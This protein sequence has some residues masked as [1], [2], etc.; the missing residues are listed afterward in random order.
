MLRYNN[1]V[2]RLAKR[3]ETH[4]PQHIID[5]FVD[6]GPLFT[7]LS[8]PDNQII[9]G[10]RGTGKTHVLG[11]LAS[12]LRKDD[13]VT[14][15]LDMRTIGS[16][17]GIYSDPNIQLG[18]R[19]TRLLVD[20]L[21]AIHDQVLTRV[22]ED[23]ETLDLSQIGPI[24][25]AFAETSTELTVEGG[26]EQESTSSGSS[27]SS[28]KTGVSFVAGPAPAI[29]ADL[30]D[31]SETSTGNVSRVKQ[32]GAQRLRV[33][34]GPLTRRLQQLVEALPAKSLWVILDEWSEVP[35]D[36]QPYLADFLRRCVIPAKGVTVKIAAIAQR[37]NF[38]IEDSSV[39]HIGMEIGADAAASLSLDEFLVFDNNPEQAK[40]FFSE[41]LY[42]HI[43]ALAKS[44]NDF[45]P[46]NSAAALTG[47][48][49]TQVTAVD[50]FAR[51]SE[52]VPRD[53][54]NIIGLAA[55]KSPN[56]PISVQD[57]RSAARTWYTRAKQQAIA[58]KPDAQRLLNWIIDEVIKHRQARAFLLEDGVRD[59]L[60]DFL[61]DARVLHVIR[62]GV[63]S[64]DYAGRRFN[65]YAIDYGCY[66][67]LINTSRAPQGLFSAG[68]AEGDG[69]EV[70]VTVPQ[71]DFRSIRRAILDL[72]E[73]YRQ[74]AVGAEAGTEA[75][76]A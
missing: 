42:R 16:T 4:D 10:R 9:F 31:K 69:Q 44:D 65:V 29:T 25:D 7:L 50:E 5:S 15:Q 8:N 23:T 63:S 57:V 18:E 26:I 46:P 1:A 51:A 2:L 14:V 22:L 74:L 53:A 20:T 40:Q 59:E 3:A 61:Y 11:Y 41:L 72:G 45:E 33:Q 56:A 55:Q 70:Y 32:S 28:S 27:T 38:R 47:E 30:A 13:I 48:L 49:F 60:I 62:E 19:A 39:G 52:G 12:E 54:I 36:L 66:V 68:L 64:Q 71:T 73:F 58:T 43:S 34:F 21:I 67:D 75:S 76:P 37:S 35:L 24:L 17:G 6:I